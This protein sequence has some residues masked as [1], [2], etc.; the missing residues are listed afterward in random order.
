MNGL[1]ANYN[2]YSAAELEKALQSWVEP[3]P[4]PIILNHDLNS[5]PI[6]RV[7]A[8]KMDKEED[9]SAFVRLQVAITDPVA[10][11]KVLDK[12]YLTGS[13]GGRAGKAVCSISGDDLAAESAD[14]RPKAQK[15]KR[16]QVY[17]GK[18]AFIDMQDISFKEYSFVNQP[19]DS[20]SGVRKSSSG[21]VKVENSSDD[22][23]ARSSAFVLSMDEEDIYSVEEHKSIL[24]GL[25]SKESK[26][27]YLHLKGS[28]LTAVAVHE[29]ENYKYN[30]DSL[31]SNENDNKEDHEENSKMEESL[32]NEDVLAAVESLSQDLS[33]IATASAQETQEP[34]EEAAAASQ[35]E[36]PEVEE[37]SNAE[38]M[39][40]LVVALQHAK[41]LN[42]ESLVELL[43]S[44]IEDLNKSAEQASPEEEP[45]AD[46]EE[47]V[48]DADAQGSEVVPESVEEQAELKAVESVDTDVAEENKVIEEPKAELTGA[49]QASE[50]DADDASKKLQL[51][52]EENQKLKSA[53]HRTL[54]ER[55]VDTKIAAGI[56]STE[57]REE[58]IAEHVKRTASSLADSLRD[59]AGLPVA[60]KAKSTM[61]EISS[62]I[63]AVESEDNV[64]TID[65]EDQESKEQVVNASEQVFVDALMGRRKL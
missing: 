14:G 57:S 35:D 52:E 44:K 21:D 40:S 55:V 12:R 54:A 41:E 58:S 51:L 33:T 29:S 61:P 16:G 42:E 31:L 27:L 48:S 3:Y 34:V 49:E 4:K 39:A 64:I 18:L 30:S 6:G 2:N 45:A 15:F 7:M 11:Q 59:L 1:T 25:K 10:I 38:L 62:E 24:K 19:A 26:P 13:V 60:K 63:E 56:E 37:K 28:F 5:E 36:K 20:K 32:Q 46:A 53:L 47:L 43:S 23:V 50:Q 8:A 9:G 22:W 17:K 65:R